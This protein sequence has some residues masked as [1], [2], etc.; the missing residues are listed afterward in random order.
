ME[1]VYDALGPACTVNDFTVEELTPKF[2]F[3]ADQDETGFGGTPG[4]PL[5]ST[6]E[7]GDNYVGVC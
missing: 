7:A 1:R 5:P 6:Q 3:Y 2:E 4:K